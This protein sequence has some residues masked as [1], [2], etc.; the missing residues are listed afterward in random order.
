L[1]SQK[2]KNYELPQKKQSSCCDYSVQLW[3]PTCQPVIYCFR[4][5][6]PL[7]RYDMKKRLGLTMY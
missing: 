5:P 6:M 1:Y 3:S 4:K 7:F 2:Q